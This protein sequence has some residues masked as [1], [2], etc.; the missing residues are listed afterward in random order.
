[1]KKSIKIVGLV[2][3]R[4]MVGT[5]LL[6]RMKTEKDFDGLT[7]I[8]FS[9]S[10]VGAE[11]PTISALTTSVPDV[12][13]SILG[14]ESILKDAYSVDDLKVCDVIISCQGGQYTN[15]MHPK[16]R[17][18]GWQGY[19]IDAASSLRM[20]PSSIIVLDPVNGEQIKKGITSGIRDFIGGNCTVSL[21]LMA[22]IGGYRAGLIEWVSSMTYQAASGAGAKA[23]SEVIEQH[24]RIA[25]NVPNSGIP[26]DDERAIVE[27]IKKGEL[28]I[29]A[30]GAPLAFNA[31]PFIDQLLDNGQSREEWKAQA[32]ATK[33][34]GSKNP[35]IID[36]LCVR[37]GALRCHSQGL[38]IKLTKDV[39]IDELSQI[40][41]SAHQWIKIV[42]NTK[43]S[44]LTHLTPV[45]FSGTLNIG[46]GRL[47]TATLGT[48]FVSAFTVGDQLLWGAAEPLRRTLK[49]LREFT[50]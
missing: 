11:A 26:L 2:G 10:S 46:L 40:L 1:M 18:S 36:G 14:Q 32:E 38:I 3:W 22:L 33:I 43:E 21:L 49:I 6:E 44:S 19:W 20:E 5:V 28:P 48:K 4:G 37:I 30:L 8:F 29:D 9:T 23:I 41:G 15:L 17:A 50:E 27:L 7:P 12:S 25:S 35:T 45:A 16:L 13:S 47:R 39:P 34:L 31:L 24:R 42:E